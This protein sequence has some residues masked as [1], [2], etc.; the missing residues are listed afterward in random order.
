MLYIVPVVHFFLL[1]A[2]KK[3]K[4]ARIQETMA[5]MCAREKVY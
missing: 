2:Y 1:L 5:N 4:Q 3:M